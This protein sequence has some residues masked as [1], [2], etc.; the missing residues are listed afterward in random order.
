MSLMRRHM[1][2]GLI[3]TLLMTVSACVAPAPSS[4]PSADQPAASSDTTAADA[5][6]SAVQIPAIE[7]GKKKNWA[8]KYTLSI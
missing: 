3:L 4:A 6:A 5:G 7:E 2:I 1:W 8:T